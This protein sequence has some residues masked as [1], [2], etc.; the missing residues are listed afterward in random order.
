MGRLRAVHRPLC[1]GAAGD[2]QAAE[3][4]LGVVSMLVGLAILCFAITVWKHTRQTVQESGRQKDFN[5]RHFCH[6]PPKVEFLSSFT[7]WLDKFVLRKDGGRSGDVNSS[8]RG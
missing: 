4:A 5:E 3:P 7:R 2:R 6:K 1:Y 8:S